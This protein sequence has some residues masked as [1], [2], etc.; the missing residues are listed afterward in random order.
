VGKT[1]LFTGNGF[2]PLLPWLKILMIFLA[3]VWLCMLLQGFAQSHSKK[4]AKFPGFPLPL[5]MAGIVASGSR[6]RNAMPTN[7]ERL[8]KVN[9]GTRS[10]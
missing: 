6:F 1:Y 7:A 2:R 9:V 8:K 4:I 3:V 10:F 5:S